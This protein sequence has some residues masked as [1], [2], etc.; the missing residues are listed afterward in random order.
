MQNVLVQY[1]YKQREQVDIRK[2]KKMVR[3]KNQLLDTSNLFLREHL[4]LMHKETQAQ[5]Y[6]PKVR[7]PQ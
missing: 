1:L 4:F 2:T 6:L 7:D 5:G 3:N